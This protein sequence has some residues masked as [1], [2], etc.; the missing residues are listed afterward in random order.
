MPMQKVP[1]KVCD[2]R[3]QSILGILRKY[4]I[5]SEEK[6]ML[7]TVLHYTLLCCFFLSETGCVF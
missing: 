2:T 5:N 3:E 4:V 6:F 7:E 1:G